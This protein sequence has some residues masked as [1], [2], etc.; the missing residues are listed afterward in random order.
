VFLHITFHL[1]DTLDPL[2]D[3][4]ILLAAVTSEIRHPRFGGFGQ[5]PP[6]LE[7]IPAFSARDAACHWNLHFKDTCDSRTVRMLLDGVCSRPRVVANSW[8]VELLKPAT[9]TRATT[10]T[11]ILS[12]IGFAAQYVLANDV[13]RGEHI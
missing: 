2:V 1:A 7:R 13:S 10:H 4:P 6:G 11:L 8:Y 12:I 9:A 3:T 5:R